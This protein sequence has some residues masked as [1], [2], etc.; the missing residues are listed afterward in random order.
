MAVAAHA[1]EAATGVPLLAAT[2]AIGRVAGNLG[3]SRQEK[4]AAGQTRAVTRLAEVAA[5]E[6]GAGTAI[7]FDAAA[8]TP[9][10]G[11][12]SVAVLVAALAVG[13]VD[14]VAGAGAFVTRAVGAV[15]LGGTTGPRFR[16]AALLVSS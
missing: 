13:A 7:A 6:V 2:H 16:V 11:A 12:A 9:F 5:A 1:K 10:P 4:V 15:G 3:Q 8:R 14:S